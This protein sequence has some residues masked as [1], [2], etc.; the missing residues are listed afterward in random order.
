MG[1]KELV[2]WREQRANYGGLGN[3]GDFIGTD[4]IQ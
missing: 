3:F 2:N 4:G 1:H